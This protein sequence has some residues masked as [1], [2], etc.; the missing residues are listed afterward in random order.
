MNCDI[1]KNIIEARDGVPW[2]PFKGKALCAS[3]YVDIIPEIYQM[4]GFGDGGIIHVI[5][6]VLLS[7]SHNRRKRIPI[8]RYRET[9]KKLLKKYNFRCVI[10]ETAESLTIDHIRPV[11]KGGTDDLNNLQILCKSCNSKKGAKWTEKAKAQNSQ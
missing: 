3:C 2:L 4:A 9:L 10:C 5:F 7:S 8:K 1:C 6:K 11:S